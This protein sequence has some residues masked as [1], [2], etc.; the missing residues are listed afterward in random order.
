MTQGGFV[1][2]ES[3]DAWIADE[4][5]HRQSLAILER[6][7]PKSSRGATVHSLIEEFIMHLSASGCD[8][9]YAYTARQRLLRLA[10]E[11]KWVMP[12]DITYLS[13]YK[14]LSRCSKYRGQAI[15]ARTKNQYID[16]AKQFG[17]WLAQ[18]PQSRLR[19]NPFREFQKPRAKH[20]NQYRRAGTLEEVNAL[21]RA[22]CPT[23]KLCYLDE[24]VLGAQVE[25]S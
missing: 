15:G 12:A 22:C 5:R 9:M 6:R 17:K 25:D 19:E 10:R 23:R 13:L 16:I 7:L 24:G 2:R 3:A 14:W 1:D 18:P 8:S 11:C 20:N 4:R 21:L